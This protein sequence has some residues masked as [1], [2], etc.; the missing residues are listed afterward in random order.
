MMPF[1]KQLI[2]TAL[3][4]AAPASQAAI[5]AYDGWD[6]SPGQS[7]SSTL[8]GGSG[9]A[10]PWSVTNNNGAVTSASLAYAGLSVIGNAFTIGG[11]GYQQGVRVLGSP[12]NAGTVYFSYLLNS[13]ALNDFS[14]IRLQNGAGSTYELGM[15][16]DGAFVPKLAIGVNYNN[17]QPNTAGPIIS[18]NATHLIAGSLDLNT[19]AVAFYY[20][21]VIANGQPPAPT[22]TASFNQAVSFDRVYWSAH[23]S[24]LDELR[25]GTTFADVVSVPEPS[26]LGLTGLCLTFLRRRRRVA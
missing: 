12:Q 6:Y 4:L 7:Y 24:T 20:D 13:T 10:S 14:G 16:F 26:S 2:L 23:N 18:Y 8:A 5:I 11:N 17:W 3:I 19:G 25:L 1:M 22:F 21:P 9:W 15:R